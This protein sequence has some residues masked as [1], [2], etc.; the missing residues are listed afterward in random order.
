[1]SSGSVADSLAAL[2][3]RYFLAGEQAQEI[4]CLVPGLSGFAYRLSIEVVNIESF[5]QFFSARFLTHFVEE[6]KSLPVVAGCVRVV[7]AETKGT[8][9]QVVNACALIARPKLFAVP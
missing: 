8:A 1:M 2:P 3:E 6:G 4:A 5:R 7:S 9:Q